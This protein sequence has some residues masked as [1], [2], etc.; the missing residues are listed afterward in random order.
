MSKYET[1][2]EVKNYTVTLLSDETHA[3]SVAVVKTRRGR[4]VACFALPKDVPTHDLIN[5]TVYSV[6]PGVKSRWHEETLNA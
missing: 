5:E 3:E 2:A 1:E 6:I 4:E